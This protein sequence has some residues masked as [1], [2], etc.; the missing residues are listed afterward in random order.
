[1]SPQIQPFHRYSWLLQEISINLPYTKTYG[2]WRA[3]QGWVPHKQHWQ[4]SSD[5]QRGMKCSGWYRVAHN[6]RHPVNPISNQR[7]K[8]CILSIIDIWVLLF[9][10]AQFETWLSE[11][12]KLTLTKKANP[13]VLSQDIKMGSLKLRPFLETTATVCSL[14]PSHE[15]RW[16]SGSW[17]AKCRH[18]ANIRI[19]SMSHLYM[20]HQPGM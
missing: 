8:L 14:S 15:R 13:Q 20:P 16:Q 5:L 7:N 18:T 3:T 2:R 12:W 1:M 6:P 17:A 10:S 9:Q 19:F 11:Y 4:A